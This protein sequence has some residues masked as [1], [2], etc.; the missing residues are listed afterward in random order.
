[1]LDYASR[2][3]TDDA[4]PRASMNCDWVVEDEKTNLVTIFFKCSQCGQKTTVQGDRVPP[5]K[6]CRGNMQKEG[7]A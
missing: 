3:L 7:R 5:T 4:E 6:V 1:M 2:Y